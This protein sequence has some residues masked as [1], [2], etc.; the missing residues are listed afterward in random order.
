M[1][2]SEFTGVLCSDDFSVYN[3]CQVGAQQKCLAH[4]KRHFK[5]ERQLQQ[6][7]NP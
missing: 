6:G 5:K 2:G 7:N 4:L 1:L 3:G